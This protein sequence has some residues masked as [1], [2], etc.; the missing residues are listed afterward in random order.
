M[1]E[2]NY[3]PHPID[4]SGVSLPLDLQALGEELARNTH[5]VWAQQR[6]RDGWKYGPFRDG[7][8]KTHP[9][10]VPYEDLSEAERQY[11]RNTSM[12]TLKVIL[13]LGYRITR[14]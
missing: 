9:D 6:I 12:E 7:D 2:K 3:V 8:Q 4:T 11:D 5:E 14:K 13:S 10:L 1:S